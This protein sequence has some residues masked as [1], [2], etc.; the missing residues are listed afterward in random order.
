MLVDG[1]TLFQVFY[2]FYDFCGGNVLVVFQRNEQ[3]TVLMRHL[4]PAGYKSQI[5]GRITAAVKA[6]HQRGGA[7]CKQIVV[8]IGEIPYL[9]FRAALERTPVVRGS[10][11]QRTAGFLRHMHGL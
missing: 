11:D 8:I 2:H 10:F 7:L 9:V 5:Q 6:H 3:E 1:V 4:I